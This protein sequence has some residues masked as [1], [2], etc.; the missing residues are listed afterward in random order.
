M[1]I[2]I[3]KMRKKGRL[4]KNLFTVLIDNK[5]SYFNKCKRV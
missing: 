2:M 3:R 4:Y 5:R 1:C